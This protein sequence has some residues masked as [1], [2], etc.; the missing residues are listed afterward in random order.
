MTAK[1]QRGPKPQLGEWHRGGEGS[2]NAVSGMHQADRNGSCDTCGKSYLKD[3]WV[4]RK[5]NGQVFGMNCCGNTETISAPAS[6]AELM[7]DDAEGREFVPI[8]QVLPKGKTKAD[9]CLSCFQITAGN[10]SCGC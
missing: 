5:P 9:M 4:F 8:S 6:Y 1:T 3:D 10:G 7:E 2:T